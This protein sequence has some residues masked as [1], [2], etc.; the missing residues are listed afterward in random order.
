MR[1][2]EGGKRKEEVGKW[3]SDS[4]GGA[5]GLDFRDGRYYSGFVGYDLAVA[6]DVD[7]RPVE[8]GRLAGVTRGAT[9]GAT[10]PDGKCRIL[11][12]SALSLH[13]LAS[14]SRGV[15]PELS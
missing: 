10:R 2:E 5:V 6:P 14:N 13:G 9:Q 12:P 4:A 11:L 15:S 3:K 7:R 1:I 8:P